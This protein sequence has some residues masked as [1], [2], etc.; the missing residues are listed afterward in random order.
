MEAFFIETPIA[1][2]VIGILSTHP[3]IEDRIAAI[4]RFAG[5]NQA[6]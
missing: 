3:R 4:Q 5:G 2:R 6:G 1:E